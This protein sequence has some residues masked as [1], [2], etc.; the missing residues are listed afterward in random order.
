MRKCE[1]NL[2]A[3][4]NSV[5]IRKMLLPK[6]QNARE[7]LL[8]A[9]PQFSPED[10]NAFLQTLVERVVYEKKKGAKPTDFKLFITPKL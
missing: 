7:V 3:V 2:E 10:R 5:E 4:D 9:Y 1:A 6:V 8:H